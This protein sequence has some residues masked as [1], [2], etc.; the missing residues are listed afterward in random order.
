MKYLKNY[1]IFEDISLDVLKDIE[2]IFLELKDIGFDIIIKD[3]YEKD[4]NVSI[5]IHPN[6]TD[7]GVFKFSEVSES[8]TR[9]IEYL[10][11]YKYTYIAYDEDTKI[12]KNE[13][14]DSTSL[15]LLQLWFTK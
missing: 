11:D 13:L 2:D 15:I 3:N 4:I 7:L 1:K 14:L 5:A 12:I 9:V 8:V 10:K 6:D